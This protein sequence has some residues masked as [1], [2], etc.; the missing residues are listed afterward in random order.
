MHDTG[1][2]WKEN[3]LVFWGEH[4]LSL[5]FIVMGVHDQVI[6]K[7]LMVEKAKSFLHRGVSSLIGIAHL[8][9]LQISDTDLEAICTHL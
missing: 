3:L 7:V 1:G 8:Y 9:G 2:T 4:Y 5:N 6:K